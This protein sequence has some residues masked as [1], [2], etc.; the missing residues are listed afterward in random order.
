VLVVCPAVALVLSLA[1]AGL[2]PWTASADPEV[3]P[4]SSGIRFTLPG[5]PAEPG[6]IAGVPLGVVANRSLSMV[7][8]TVEYDPQALTFV[9]VCIHPNVLRMLEDRPEG[10]TLLDWYADPEEG[11][12][13]VSLVTDFLGRESQSIP[14]GLLASLATLKFWVPLDAPRGIHALSFPRPGA[15]SFPGNFQSRKG[16]V[17]N[18][19]RGHGRPFS[20]D[21]R[22]DGSST[23]EVEDGAIM[24]SIIGDVGIF[25]GDANLDYVV[26][27]SDPKCILESLFLDGAPLENLEAADANAD[28]LVNISDPVTILDYLFVGATDWRPSE[29]EP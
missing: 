9:Q 5:V 20:E 1:L 13:Q 16:P 11:W 7:S 12:L 4:D 25:R 28:G 8:W 17:Y 2:H 10:E 23:P 6:E 22:F 18:A 14:P 3:D 29:I 19:A 27:V 21:D 24:V 26:D 15:A